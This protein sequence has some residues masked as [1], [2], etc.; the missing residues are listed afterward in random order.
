M[1]RVFP[2]DSN[3]G[4]GDG[5][6]SWSGLLGGLGEV[7]GDMVLFSLEDTDVRG[8]NTNIL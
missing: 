7:G 1:G 2:E 6:K 8:E 4:G 3:F 5:V